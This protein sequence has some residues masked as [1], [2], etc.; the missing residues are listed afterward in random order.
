MPKLLRLNRS[1]NAVRAFCVLVFVF[2]LALNFMTPYVA[3]DYVYRISF[4]TKE[5]LRT[6]ADLFPSMYVHCFRMNGRVISHFLGQLFMLAP[7]AVFNLCNAVVGTALLLLLYRTA[8]HGREENLLL[9]AAICAAM[10]CWTPAFGQVALWQ[11]GS[12]NYLWGLLAGMLYL[13]P[14]LSAFLS[15]EGNPPPKLWRRLLFCVFSLAVGMYTEVASFIVLFLAVS[16][17]VLRPLMK[18]GGWKTWLWTPAALTAAGY[19][20][21]LSM[22]AEAAAKQASMTPGV[23]LSNFLRSTSMLQ[24]YGKELLILWVVLFI[25]GLYAKLPAER[26][27]LSLLFAMGA[28]AAD[29]MLIVA[30]YFPERCFCT[31]T[32]LLVLACATTAADLCAS[33]FRP[34]CACGGGVL[35][36]LLAFSLILGAGD[37]FNTYRAFLN[38]EEIIREHVAQGEMDVEL[39]LIHASTGYSAFYG[40]LDL[41]TEE[42]ETWPNMQMAQYYGLHSILGVE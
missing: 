41:N 34:V 26:M 4:A 28:V 36:V 23:L 39:P 22:P 31:T 20:I 25:L 13:R 42:T 38:R 12:V 11:L 30:S 3:D 24:T 15:P 27:V 1:R 6:L 7:K 19:L 16:L 5:P 9:L 35:A 21:L 37:I 32:M 10:W 8:H 2:L 40:L 33:R 14:F 17:L 29:Y 18:R